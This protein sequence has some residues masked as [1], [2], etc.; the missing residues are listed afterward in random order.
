M[1]AYFILLVIYILDVTKA[2][3]SR[4]TYKVM[5][6]YVRNF[7]A[8]DADEWDRLSISFPLDGPGGIAAVAAF[9]HPDAVVENKPNIGNFLTAI[10][11]AGTSEPGMLAAIHAIA[12][13][14]ATKGFIVHLLEE[15][16]RG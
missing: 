7:T 8:L 14:P 16:K 1:F 6:A 12:D 10:S 11:G 3:W 2:R 13:D 5:G 4:L 9:C 15:D